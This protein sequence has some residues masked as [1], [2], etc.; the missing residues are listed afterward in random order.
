MRENMKRVVISEFMDEG[1]VER[2]KAECEVHWDKMLVDNREELLRAVAGAKAL[3]IRNKT[4]VD[5]ELLEAA[6]LLKVVGRLGVGL[7]NIDL[8]ACAGR[9]VTVCPAT[10]ANAPSV[11]EYVLGSAM[12]LVRGAYA[13]SHRIV[14]GE[15][16]RSELST[17]G[18]LA[19]RTMGIIGF[20]GIGQR[21][22]GSAAALGMAVIAYDPL[23][24]TND[25]AWQRAQRKTLDQVIATADVL[26]L[27]VPLNNATRHLIDAAA[28]SRMKPG[29]VLVNTA[30]G[31]IIDEVALA[32]ALRSGALGG[33][34]IDVFETEPA[35]ADNMRAF[36]GLS[37]VILT[38][39]IAGLTAEA[40]ARVSEL[41]VT[42]VLNAL[43][44]AH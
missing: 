33:A 38:P 29:A 17:G 19:G 27:H 23:L 21:L 39:H 11:V 9:G 26:S 30:R 4:R 40:N 35:T 28:L 20:G 10:G 1:P 37:N 15:W 13:S 42:N 18:E 44:D 8:E 25:P 31:G 34:A 22:A 41:T 6:P 16:P 32:G 14:S 24:P 12:S 2:L 5:V 7:D 43:K 36:T 3:I